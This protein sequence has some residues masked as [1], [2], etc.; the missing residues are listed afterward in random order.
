M[1]LRERLRCLERAAEV[2]TMMVVCPEC[3]EEFVVHPDTGLD[4]LVWI[5][6][7][8]YQGETYGETL[9]D[10]SRLV[11]HAHDASLF[12]LKED[13]S[14]WLGEFFRGVRQEVLYV[15]EDLSE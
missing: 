15:Q 1:G 14:A 5:W 3:G 8:D 9:P 6:R 7:E 13:G 11:A 2:D 4:Y 12:V 10:V